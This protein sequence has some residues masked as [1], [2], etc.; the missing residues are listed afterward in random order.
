M[1]DEIDYTIEAKNAIRFAQNFGLGL[2]GTSE[3]PKGVSS[4]EG[5]QIESAASWLRTPYV[6]EDLSTEKLLVMEYVPSI[7][8]NNNTLLDLA[9]VTM[10]QRTFLANSL[11]R[12]YLYQ[13]CVHKFL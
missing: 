11:A 8:V 9:N 7:K 6:Y 1:S 4:Y 13:F 10:E 12:S 3:T 5:A 2:D